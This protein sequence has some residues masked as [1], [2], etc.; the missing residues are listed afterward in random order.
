MIEYFFN[1]RLTME[2]IIVYE[3]IKSQFAV[4]TDDAEVL[5]NLLNEHL[6]NKTEVRVDFSN[7]KTI[8]TAFFNVSIGNLYSSW[9]RTE[10][11]KYIHI[12]ADTLTNLQKDKLKLVMDNTRTK[13]SKGS[14]L[15]K[16][17]IDG[18]IY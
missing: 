14:G 17:N 4:S 2:K 18:E 8:T 12:T 10:L 3:L 13:L 6:K 15:K 1:W 11:N 9:D 16:P 5:F 7:L